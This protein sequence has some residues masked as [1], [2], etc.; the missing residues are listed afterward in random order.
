M[1]NSNMS[2]RNNRAS[3]E[4]NTVFSDINQASTSGIQPRLQPE[5][6]AS[7]YL[8]TGVTAGLTSTSQSAS[9][10]Q[11]PHDAALTRAGRPR[12]RRK[13]TNEINEALLRAYYRITL[14]ETDLTGYRPRLRS[15]FTSEYR[16]YDVTEQRLADQVRVIHRNNLIPEIRRNVIKEEVARELNIPESDEIELNISEDIPRETQQNSSRIH[17]EANDSNTQNT[18][19]E[20]TKQI[21]LNIHSLYDKTDP[22]KRP[23]I[24]KINSSI[25]VSTILQDIND[26]ILPPIVNNIQDIEGLQTVV[27]C[28]AITMAIRIEKKV[29]INLNNEQQTQRP[30]RYNERPWLKRLNRKIEELRKNISRINNYLKPN[31]QSR[32]N[33]HKVKMICRAF[34]KH[35]KY[36]NNDEVVIRV[37]DTLKQTLSVQ[38]QKRKR[39]LISEQ[40]KSSNRMF[41]VNEKKFY[42]N[43]NQPIPS[44]SEPNHVP[45]IE[46][47]EEY[48]SSLWDRTRNHRNAQWMKDEEEQNR[49]LPEMECQGISAIQLREALQR[50]HN[51]KA[52]G[53]DKVQNFWYK[54]LTAVHLKLAELFS[55]CLEHPDL[56]PSSLTQGITY[57]LPKGK[58]FQ[59][60]PSKGR[61]ITC[62]NTIYKLLT[63]CISNAIYDHLMINN[64]M[65]EEQKGC[66]KN[67][68]GC[69]EQ[70]TID[71][72]VL[73]QATKNSRN[74]YACYI[75]YQKCFDSL[76]HSWL[77]KVLS[78]YKINPKIIN[79]LTSIMKEWQTS[80]QINQNI[81]HPLNTNTSVMNP[82]NTH[83][84]L[85]TKAIKIRKGI[86]QGDCLSA[87]WFC[88]ALNP[89]SNILRK[90]KIG[91]NLR[92]ESKSVHKINH[93]IYMDDLKLYASTKAH[94]DDLI[95]IV[96]NFSKDIQMEFGLDKCKILC[97][98]A[99]KIK[100]PEDPIPMHIQAMETDEL[101][102]YLGMMQSR[103]IAHS[104]MKQK[105]QTEFK[106]RLYKILKS[107]LN[108]KNLVKAIN[109]YA[110][111]VITYSFG[112]IKWTKTDLRNLQR[113]I[114]TTMT[115]NN[116]H[117]P[118]SCIERMSLPRKEGGRGLIDI[119]Q[120]HDRQ[121][122]NL[123]NYFHSKANTSDLIK[124]VV[125]VDQKLTP[126]NLKSREYEFFSSTNQ[127][128]ESRWSQKSLHGRYYHSLHN[129]NVDQEMSN[130]WL[131]DGSVFSETE[132]FMLAIQDEV[133]ATR[134]YMKHII[135]CP[136]APE[137]R[138]R[139]CGSPGETID[140]IISA[141]PTLTQ[142]DYLKRHNNVAK[143]IH[144]ELLKYYKV[145]PHLPYYY[146]Y[147]PEP[148]IENE[149]I[150]IYFDRTIRSGHTREHNRPDLTIV[151]KKTKSAT[152]IDIAVPLSRN[153]IKTRH[154]KISKYSELAVEMKAMW[155][156]TNIR[157][158]P[159][160]IS[161]IGL[162]PKG[163]REDLASLHL[164][165]DILKTI[166]KA[167]IIDTC[168]TVRKF[169]Q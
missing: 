157:I 31:H 79:F 123:R 35:S 106:S 115:E 9:E 138:C 2:R 71:Q 151:D 36:E 50:T 15:T 130:R 167:V 28:A 59:G 27:Y 83:N 119:E 32:R 41:C 140:H 76:P 142:S 40:R 72:V 38:V 110:I 150:K 147:T 4:T 168:H 77:L 141:C 69:K 125:E 105:L 156:L 133:I 22:S 99:G 152:I 116:A 94:L 14:L 74:L 146:S 26:N 161:S 78:I 107:K 42:R 45:S 160:I 57:L 1:H 101:Y 56:F 34:N 73:E 44:T 66:I 17:V 100:D 80:I 46:R 55:Q 19:D 131:T 102:K 25:K 87:L 20:R 43:L 24:P 8:Q 97:I 139:R 114:R 112:I 118:K 129:T 96:S 29:N 104:K 144:L 65:A 33:K 122:D 58:S 113:T 88:M 67:A 103:Q 166:Q 64:I 75:D 159:I 92:S 5:V 137:D 6:D 54:R 7:T 86:F 89:L 18:A 136:N 82:E 109:T 165:P 154:E 143:I 120:Q 12:M 128:K 127:D 30:T 10:Q 98:R 68:R 158:V 60:D 85:R 111:P 108:G 48:W 51:W 164:K 52:P 145:T 3:D 84:S 16:E 91:F 163:L 117:H 121:V 126:L 95:H 49:N 169:L 124:A 90:T 63:S 70:L 39:Y 13:W 53:P 134:N 23:P 11:A 162:I 81:N 148:V 37:L 149:N 61:P 62:L 93:L 135:K 47:V 153:M 132:G 21:F 155:N